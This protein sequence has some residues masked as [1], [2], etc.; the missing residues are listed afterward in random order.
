M[1]VG[2]ATPGHAESSFQLN[3]CGPMPCFVRRCSN[4]CNCCIKFY[5]ISRSGR[6]E[7]KNSS[8]FS[9]LHLYFLIKKHESTEAALLYPRTE[10]TRTLSVLCKACSMKSDISF[11]I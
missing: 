8:V 2:I 3:D 9:K 10:C 6:L 7:L 4:S 11:E 5:L 1:F